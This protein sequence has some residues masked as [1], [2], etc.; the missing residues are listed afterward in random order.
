MEKADAIEL[1]ISPQEIP[2]HEIS[3]HRL[4]FSDYN[5]RVFCWKGGIY[6]AIPPAQ[7]PLY[8]ELFDRGAVR[9]LTAQKLLIPTALTNLTLGT[10]ALI[11]KHRRIPAIAY[12]AEWCS[13]ML[14]AA[15]L[16]HLDLC[17]AL[18]SYDCTTDDAHPINILFEGP[19]PYFVDFGSINR[20]DPG[21]WYPWPWPPYEQFCQTF[22][23]PLLLK[24]RGQERLAKWGLHDFENGILK[25]DLNALINR[26][27]STLR[28]AEIGA[29]LVHTSSQPLDRLPSPVQPLARRG[30]GAIGRLIS[31]ASGIQPT[32]RAF[33][34]QVR[35]EVA[36]I[37]LPEAPASIPPSKP[38][39]YSLVDDLLSQ[40]KPQ[41]VLDINSGD[42]QGSYARLAA[43]KGARVIAT[44][45][46]EASLNQIYQQAK[47]SQA[48][49]LPV[50]MNFASPSDGLANDFLEP[51]RDRLQCDLVIA[52]TLDPELLLKRGFSFI[53]SRLAAFTTRWLLIEFT[54]Q[55]RPTLTTRWQE[56][57][58][59]CPWYQLDNL[60]AALKTQFS[61]V[62]T[63]PS[64]P[65]SKSL[66]L[67]EK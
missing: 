40:L 67:C 17:I 14:K 32:R 66:L 15:A 56:K 9:S 23:Y 43:Q 50:R 33:L 20:L 64:H 45:P 35:A 8:Q 58:I 47:A 11:L 60:I 62:E 1:G 65:A 6:R 28:L 37:S 30:C 61:Q 49:I 53:A 3:A 5:G 44:D 41:S 51:A 63:I 2:S 4:S 19:T 16:L 24:A 36:N 18:D 27:L 7:A 22:L 54:P 46:Q 29:D 10:T 48:D 52:L 57:T 39:N 55:E 38:E 25:S 34:Q 26:P 12:P 42:R 21:R 59:P 13:A 31:K